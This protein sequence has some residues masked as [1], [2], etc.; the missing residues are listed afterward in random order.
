M[1]STRFRSLLAVAAATVLAAS[2]TS[3]TAVAAPGASGSGAV[4]KVNVKRNGSTVKQTPMAPCEIGATEDAESGKVIVGDVATYY[5]GSTTCTSTATD[6][7]AEV[8]VEG[9]A[10]MTDVLRSAGGPRI[11][12]SGYDVSCST[13]DNSSYG[14]VELRGIRG[15]T[16]PQNIPVNYK[17]T[18]PGRTSSAPPL[19]VVTLNQFVTPRPPD[20]SM[21]L[22]AMTIKLYPQ[23]GPMSG[24]IT[25][26]TVA[27]DPYGG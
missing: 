6:E 19:A 7:E 17:V 2:L 21:K 9:D 12:L 4:G 11:R 27:C 14:Q 5:G 22:N 1:S 25:V 20:G 3:A 18:V 16:V 8:A 10:F 26:G 13:D 24:T 15:I 23:G